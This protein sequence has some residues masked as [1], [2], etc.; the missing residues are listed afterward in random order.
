[1]LQMLLQPFE[2]ILPLKQGLN[3]QS[4]HTQLSWGGA[5]HCLQPTFVGFRLVSY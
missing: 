1:M 3:Q 2:N 4:G 5:H